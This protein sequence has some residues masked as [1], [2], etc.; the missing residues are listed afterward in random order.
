MPDQSSPPSCRVH[1]IFIAFFVFLLSPVLGYAEEAAIQN[2]A[3]PTV[4]TTDIAK[5]IDPTDFKN[6]FDLRSEYIEYATASTQTVIPRFEYAF[7]KSLGFRTE[8]PIVRYDPASGG[9]TAGIGNLLTRLAWRAMR[10][11]DVSVVVGSE[12][13]F[14]TASST[15]L[16][17]GKHVLAPFA[18]AAFDVPRAK[19]VFF[20][21]IQYAKAVGGDASRE[22]VQYTNIRA[23]A[24]TRWPEKIYSFVEYSYFIDHYRANVASSQIKA[25]VGQF[26]LPKTGFYVRPGAGLSGTD[27]KLGMRWS[28]E[29][30]IRHFF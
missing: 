13:I 23:S 10:T 24:L 4:S 19:S 17:S 29:L 1:L 11:D 9:A 30:G 20:P 15:T 3:P 25:E 26:V 8:L 14:D 16:G 2:A 7:S 21:Y 18:F 27:Q 6:R 12:L 28:F 5:R 22:D